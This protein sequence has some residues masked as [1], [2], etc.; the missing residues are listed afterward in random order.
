[1]S[2]ISA[3]EK[4]QRSMSSVIVPPR[5]L[6]ADDDSSFSA[7]V[8][9]LLSDNGYL[10]ECVA[11]GQLATKRLEEESF[12]ALVADIYMPGNRELQLLRPNR[13]VVP[14]VLVTGD[15]T[16]ETAIGALRQAVVDYLIKPVDAGALLD[17]VRSAVEKSKAIQSL[18]DAK[19][20]IAVQARSLSHMDSLLS[21]PG[22]SRSPEPSLDRL[23]RR[24]E[25]LTPRERE[26]T[27]CR[28]GGQSVSEIA[29]RLDISENTVRNHFKS[30]FRK[31]GIHSQEELVMMTMG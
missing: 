12:D 9:R 19:D 13:G 30:I 29:A 28:A 31:L 20:E 11:D 16:V 17:A 18:R 8:D 15:P 27:L 4:R 14:I 25:R 26:I 7:M 2:L 6:I 10:C 24:A 23:G 21:L 22:S 5:V 1:M 3:P